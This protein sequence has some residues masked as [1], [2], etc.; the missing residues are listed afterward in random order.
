MIDTDWLDELTLPPR[1][2]AE[3]TGGPDVVTGEH[4]QVCIVWADRVETGCSRCRQSIA[5]DPGRPAML[6]TGACQGGQVEAYSQ[7]HGCGEWLSVAW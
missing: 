1:I 5:Q 4:I 6:N 3:L 7:Q 2:H